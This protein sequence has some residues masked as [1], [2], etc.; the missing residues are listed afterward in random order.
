MTN[1][2]SCPFGHLSHAYQT[3]AISKMLNKF[4]VKDFASHIHTGHAGLTNLLGMLAT[5]GKG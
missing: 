3:G 2:F 4:D 1:I 5:S